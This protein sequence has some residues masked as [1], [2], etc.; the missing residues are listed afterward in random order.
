MNTPPKARRF[1]THKIVA[2]PPPT[3]AVLPDMP[4]A[5]EPEDDGFGT[6][7]LDASARVDEG[8]RPIPD[9]ATSEEIGA[10]RA[11]GLTGRQLRMARRVAMRN[12]LQAATDIEAVAL[13]RRKGIE[14][15]QR[16][17]VADLLPA[18]PMQGDQPGT[19]LPAVSDPQ[20]NLPAPPPPP[21]DLAEERARAIMAMQRDIV[22]RRRRNFMLLMTRLAIFVFLPTF[23]AGYYYSQLATPLYATSSEF[24]IQQSEGQGPLGGLFK[25]TQFGSPQDAITVQSYLQSRD[26]LLRLDKEQGFKA[27]FSQGFIDPLSRLDEGASNEA[28]YRLYQRDVKIAYDPTEGVIKMEVTAVDPQTS[29]RFSRALIGY[30]EEQVDQLTQRMREDQMKGALDSYADA[31]A[32]VKAAQLRVSELQQKLG[33]LD[34]RAESSVTMGQIAELEG[35]LRKKKLELGQLLDNAR[36]N[37]ARVDGAKGDIA[38][39]EGQLSELRASLTG[40]VGGASPDAASLSEVTGQ[41]RIAEGELETR[42]L[43]LSKALEHQETA[44]IEANRQVRYLSVGVN[45]VPPDEPTYPRAFE[46]TALAF[47]IFAGI[48][49]VLSLTASILREQVTS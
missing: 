38:R 46:D 36:P 20:R 17:N 31:E 27:H 15:F 16:V 12:G 25:G 35:A 42:Q 29:A 43:M 19:H 49:L 9:P 48:Y 30:A 7:K 32:K 45:P 23:L 44:R 2:P 26:A 14:P 40:A 1:R 33:V 18:D 8:A 13:L 28:A 11:E 39:M 4:F 47:M 37:Q 3:A 10:I 22:R 34:P 24:V 41:L 6:L 21:P 5:P